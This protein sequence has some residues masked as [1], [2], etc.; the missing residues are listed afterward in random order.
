M[1]CLYVVRAKT[2]CAETARGYGT[3]ITRGAAASVMNLNLSAKSDLLIFL[4]S[5][6][7]MKKAC[8]TLLSR[9][10]EEAILKEQVYICR[11][12][13]D[14]LGTKFIILFELWSFDFSLIL[15][16]EKWSFLIFLILCT[17]KN[18]SLILCFASFWF[19]TVIWF[20]HFQNVKFDFD[21]HNCWFL[22]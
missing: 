7:A 16:F 1:N 14:F 21:L 20:Q 11:S 17:L 3:Y 8:E 4:T 19:C 22:W 10:S 6:F 13:L 2:A 15:M 9:D 12:M 18:D 5:N